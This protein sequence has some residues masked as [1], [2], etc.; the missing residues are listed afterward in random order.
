MY[1]FTR[2]INMKNIVAYTLLLFLSINV[3]HSG[4]GI[5]VR[6]GVLP[7]MPTVNT[8]LRLGIEAGL[9]PCLGTGASYPT[10]FHLSN[11]NH[12]TFVMVGM[13]VSPCPNIGGYGLQYEIGSL[14]AG[15]YTV[16]IY[17]V[18]G[19][20]SVPQSINDPLV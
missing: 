6:S 17:I 18:S 8:P 10:F 4:Q 3:A 20:L 2:V 11:D 15:D 9:N 13:I 14:P 5:P 7:E 19:P 16:Q 1:F 12:I